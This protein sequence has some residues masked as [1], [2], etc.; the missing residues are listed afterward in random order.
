MRPLAG[1]VVCGGMSRRMGR[2]KPWLEL[3]GEAMLGRTVRLL[4]TVVRPVVVV[5]A[6]RQSLPPLPADVAI[7]IDR[8]AGRGPMEGLA[9]GLTHLVGRSEAAFASSCDAPFLRP[10][11]AGRLASLIG[12]KF[13]CVPRI[14]SRIHPLA[15]LY[16]LEILDALGRLLREGRFRL[17]DLFTVVPTRY[18]EAQELADIDPRLRSFWNINTPEDYEAALREAADDEPAQR[19]GS[20]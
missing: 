14:G 11:L 19:G 4:S 15:S 7:L 6:P 12:D 13:A 20:R 18:V 16:R 17:T 5:A 8:Q 1:I 10:A 2:P 9:T 3:S